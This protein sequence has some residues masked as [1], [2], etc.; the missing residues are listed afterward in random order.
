MKTLTDTNWN[1]FTTN[2]TVGDQPYEIVAHVF[3]ETRSTPGEYSRGR[4]EQIEASL[5]GWDCL[6]E[7]TAEHLPELERRLLE[8]IEERK[9]D[10]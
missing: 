2:I 6:P 9:H 8:E 7:P 1:Q 4:E 10:L 5:D 3:L